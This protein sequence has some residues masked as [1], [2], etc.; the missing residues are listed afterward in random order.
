MIRSIC[1]FFGILITT[2]LSAQDE[3]KTGTIK[4]STQEVNFGVIEKN[5]NPYRELLVTNTGDYPL[6]INS[7]KATCGCTVPN[8]PVDPIMP[9]KSAPI[10]VR[11]NTANIGKF[12]KQITVYSN[13]QKNP[14]TIIRLFGEVIEK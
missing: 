9:K 10:Q 11:Y 7:C 6:I 14:I 2:S 4:F 8:C 13:D 12:S 1:L 5:S 3:L